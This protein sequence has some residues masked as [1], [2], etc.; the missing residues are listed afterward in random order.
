MVLLNVTNDTKFV[1]V[2]TAALCTKRLLEGE[3]DVIDHRVVEHML[4]EAIAEAEGQN[5][6]DHFLAEVVVNPESFIL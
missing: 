1:K 3:L 4:N 6:F 2:A 5:V